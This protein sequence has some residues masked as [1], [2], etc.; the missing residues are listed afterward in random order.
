MAKHEIDL[1]DEIS[2]EQ[3]KAAI[4]ALGLADAVDVDSFDFGRLTIDGSTVTLNAR[5]KHRLEYSR[6]WWIEGGKHPF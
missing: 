2:I 3:V 5:T 6:E 4:A 1:P